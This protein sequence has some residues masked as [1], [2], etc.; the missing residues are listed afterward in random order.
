MATTYLRDRLRRFGHW[1]RTLVQP[2]RLEAEIEEE[3]Q[4]HS[5][6]DPR[7]RGQVEAAKEGWRQASDL[8]SLQTWAWDVRYGARLLRRSPLF[9][10][11]AVA[12]LGLGI[13]LNLALFSL[14]K[15]VLLDPLPYAQAGQLY[16]LAAT[17]VSQRGGGQNVGWMTVEDW[18]RQSRDFTGIASYYY[19]DAVLAGAAG[20]PAQVLKGRRISA[21][22]FATLGVAPELGRTFT[23]A[24]EGPKRDHEVVLSHSYWMK[25]FAGDRGAVGRT[26][27][28]NGA[29]NTI[30]GVMP[31][32][33]E[34]DPFADVQAWMPEGYDA[35]AEDACRSCQHLHAIG[36]LAPGAS[37]GAAAAE[38]NAVQKRLA[39]AYPKDYPPDSVVAMVPLRETVVGNVRGMLWM[40][41]AATGAVLLIVCANLA[42]LLLARASERQREMAVRAAL[43]AGRARIM[44]Q[45]L[46]EGAL[47]GVLGGV[48]G[49]ALAWAALGGLGAWAAAQLPRL[50]G[51]V[52]DGRVL[53]AGAG[54]SI[55]AGVLIGLP[56]ALQA[57][58]LEPD[59][60]LHGSRGGIGSGNGSR[61]FL[62]GA[63]VAL[64]AVLA[65]GA[66]LVLKSFVNVSRVSPGFDA[67]QVFTA[68]F[69][70]SGPGYRSDA[71]QN[72]FDQQLTDELSATPRVE[73]AG[74]VS[75]LP[76]DPGNYDTRGYFSLDPPITS[77]PAMAAANMFFDTYFV[78][79]GYF[80]AMRIRLRQG[81]LFR[82]DDMQH[83]GLATIVDESLARKLWPGRSALGMT[84][85]LPGSFRRTKQWSR[86]VGVVED[87][88][89]YGLDRAPTPEVY[90]P[91]PLNAGAAGT[92]VVRSAMT[93]GEVEA[94]VGRVLARLDTGVP[95]VRPRMLDT[96]VAGAVAQRRLTLELVGAFGALALALAALGIY[97]VVAYTTAAR[98][99]E[100]GMRMAL[101]AGRRGIMRLVL[102]SGMK[103]VLAGLAA[104]VAAALGAGQLLAGML[105]EVGPWDPVVLAGVVGLLGVVA[106]G[107]SAAPAWRASRMDPARALRG[108]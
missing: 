34:T 85:A 18:K 95:M 15:R 14:V 68:D 40:L 2:R 44:R 39:A 108:E 100:I 91:Y 93:P 35:S 69:Y 94:T 48:A 32:G 11:A 62:V 67:A 51:L 59:A 33:I 6:L 17:S 8:Y 79:P 63:E 1:W 103:P 88:H 27:E 65:A 53:L 4:H 47:L 22:F 92:L 37:A 55:A 101:G 64:A 21:N 107:A 106:T 10:A 89:Q 19:Q 75:V 86:V 30:I 98:Q 71:A 45:L 24:E 12:T 99:G 77:Q 43:G 13:G 76:L 56:P 36:R 57:A 73:A 96:V 54:L 58:R 7:G 29:A 80:A 105:F 83:P 23:D 52:L 66:G 74:V 42:N 5:A 87:V 28:L 60:A 41:L 31:A 9:A 70:L 38:M 102:G 78:S 3:L 81:R 90:L 104:G 82:E 50:Q 61:R 20:A 49:A 26:L 25:H 72:H 97:G 46:T 16:Q 84:L